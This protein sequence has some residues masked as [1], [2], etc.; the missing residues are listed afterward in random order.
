MGFGRAAALRTVLGL[1]LSS[2]VIFHNFHVLFWLIAGCC[3]VLEFSVPTSA[4]HLRFLN[5]SSGSIWISVGNILPSIYQE[6]KNEK[7][8]L[9]RN[10][11]LYLDDFIRTPSA[12][13]LMHDYYM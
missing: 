1:L 9:Q 12:L 10:R 2:S 13:F 11:L 8:T 4:G 3:N 7:L 5:Y 6:S